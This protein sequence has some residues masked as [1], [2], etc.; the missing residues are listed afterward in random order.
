MKRLLGLSVVYLSLSALP[1]VASDECAW[2]GGEYSLDDF[3]IN[4]DFSVNADCT[5]LVWDWLSDGLETT[6]LTRTKHGWKGELDRADVEL[7]ENGHN[8][9]VTGNGGA[10]RQSRAERKN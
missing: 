7:L 2:A 3:G 6:A 4:G 8:L 1:A 10:M 5:Q 9:R